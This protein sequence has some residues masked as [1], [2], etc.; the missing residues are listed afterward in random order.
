M[1]EINPLY[2]TTSKESALKHILALIPVGQK[3]QFIGLLHVFQNSI[4]QEAQ[5]EHVYTQSDE[6][7]SSDT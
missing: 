7:K 6:T 2:P 1:L 4:I 3:N 5:N